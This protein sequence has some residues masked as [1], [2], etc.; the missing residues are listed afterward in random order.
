MA[1]LWIPGSVL[2]DTDI[3]S[4]TTCV[5]TRQVTSSS[6]EGD[7]LPSKHGLAHE[8]VRSDLKAL[9]FNVVEDGEGAFP[10]RNGPSSS[11]TLIRGG[12]EAECGCILE[13]AHFWSLYLHND[14][15]Y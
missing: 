9:F 1:G 6:L 3:P 4:K 8:V 14:Q 12:G 7:L 5:L 15:P 11:V 10:G 2:R 13:K